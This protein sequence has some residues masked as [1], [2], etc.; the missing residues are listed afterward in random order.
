MRKNFKYDVFL[1]YSPRDKA[2]VGHLAELLKADGL[3]IW[4]DEWEISEQVIKKIE[5][6]ELKKKVPQMI[7]EGLEDSQTFVLCMSRGAFSSD[8][9]TL[10]R[11][12]EKYRAPDDTERRFVPLLLDDVEIGE[13]LRQFAYIDWR[14]RSATEYSRLLAACRPPR[15]LALVSERP[16]ADRKPVQTFFGHTKPVIGVA[17]A[18]HLKRIISGSWDQTLRR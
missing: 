7:E 3:R 14:E 17:E 11:Q 13:T 9:S 6:G 8:W 10:E 5:R 2:V 16:T 15:D 12:T 18:P 1:G 4:F